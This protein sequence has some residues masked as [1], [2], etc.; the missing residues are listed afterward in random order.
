MRLKLNKSQEQVELIQAMASKDSAVAAAAQQAFAALAGKVVQEVIGQAGTASLIF[1]DMEYAADDNPSIPL[2]LFYD[3]AAGYVS[4]WSQAI[5]GGLASNTI[6]GVAD[7]KI[8]T[9]RL[10]TAINIAKKYIR[11]A[12]LDV[13]AKGLERMAQ[14]MLLKQERNAWT[15][16]MRGLAEAST[17][18]TK[19]TITT[20]TESVFIPNDLNRLNTLVK[21]L[22]MSFANGTPDNKGGGSKITDLFVSYEITEAIRGFAYNPV[23]NIGSQST[24]PIT[25]PEGARSE[26]WRSGGSSSLWGITIHE[27]AELGTSRKYNSLFAEFATSNVGHGGNFA[28]SDDEIAIGIDLVNDCFIRPVAIDA[29]TGSTVVAEV[30]DQYVKRADKVGWFCGLTE[31]RVGIDLRKC[32]GLVV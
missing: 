26:I 27:L 5:N 25:L 24:G 9:Y 32:V 17:A 3:Q 16:I 29:D 30:D 2:D 21:R 31:G 1:R 8:S 14:E 23:N 10:D 19:H 15:V 13:V 22:N 20:S 18:G 4:I 7:M 12:R 6:E 11:K 28:N